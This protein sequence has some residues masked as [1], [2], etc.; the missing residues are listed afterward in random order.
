MVGTQIQHK[1]VPHFQIFVAVD[2]SGEVWQ[3]PCDVKRQNEFNSANSHENGNQSH[4]C[5]Q[6]LLKS[7]C[8]LLT[9]AALGKQGTARIWVTLLVHFVIS[10]L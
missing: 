6:E 2:T 1:Q 4:K 10:F 9:H 8:C 5:Q 3:K 7:V